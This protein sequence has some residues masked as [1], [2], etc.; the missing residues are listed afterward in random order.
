MKWI[1]KFELFKESTQNTIYKNKNIIT[2]I[3]VSMILLNPEFLDKILDLGIKARY[4]ENSSVFLTDLKNL[5]LAKN[6]LKLGKFEDNKCVED[7][8]ISKINGLFNN[9]DFS[10]EED[11]NQL[12]DSR[13]VARNII[14]KL[15]P[16][17]KLRP[18][19]I[20]SIFWI[21]PNK[22]KEFSED[23]VIELE[24]G[25]QYSFFLN[26]NFSGQKSASFATFMDDLIGE[27]VNNLFS[28]FYIDKWNKL[29]Q[30]WMQII[31]TNANKNIQAHIEKFIEK[32]RIETIDWFGYFNIKHSDPKFQYLGEYMREF[33]KN[34]L[35][36]SELMNLIWKNREESFMDPER[37]YKE[38]MEVKTFT[39][40]SKILE[41]ILTE[42]LTKNNPGEIQKLESGMKRAEGKV[43]MKFIKTIVEKMGCIEREVY[44][45]GNKGNEFTK[46]PSRDFFRKNYESMDV[47]FDYHVKMVISTEEERNDFR[48][49]INLL[50]DGKDLI[51]TDIFVRFSGGI[52]ERLSAKYKFEPVSNFNL[53]V[54]EK[55]KQVEKGL[56]ES[57]LNL[58]DNVDTEMIDVIKNEVSKGGKILEISCGNASDA[59][60]LKKKGFDITC[61]E[62]S[63]E[64]YQNAIEKGLNCILH[65]TREPFPFED[66]SFDLIYSRLGLHYFTETELIP[67]LEELHR[68]GDKL[69]FSVK[70]QDDNFKTGKVIL[71]KSDWRE[72][73]EDWWDIKFIEEK[74][75]ELYGSPSKWIEVLAYRK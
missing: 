65:N 10:F 73:L 11:F 52:S 30:S 2:E 23:I 59:L 12:V 68:I 49:K 36:L 33:D 61:T 5:L 54:S 71:S 48:I 16:E 74:S 72:L 41:H 6:R 8:E 20:R 21:G 64:Y 46:I 67:I 70:T 63:D 1:K 18:E 9:V 15:L 3:C 55:N 51:N 17:E 75:G 22:T 24:T 58:V 60:F 50:L 57:L 4:T 13:I 34:V 56:N 14:D 43:K 62:I 19:M 37:I 39:L 44:Y 29:I 35:T 42:S 32:D 47:E 69:L 26:K 31:Y 25:N 27:E 40:N 66:K 38:W 7:T 28:G 45:L 53:I